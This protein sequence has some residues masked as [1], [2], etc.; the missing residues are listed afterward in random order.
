[1]ANIDAKP[2]ILNTKSLVKL[3]RQL[4][5]DL[6]AT[7]ISLQNE[8]QRLNKAVVALGKAVQGKAYLNRDLFQDLSRRLNERIQNLSGSLDAAILDGI[9]PGEQIR[10]AMADLYRCQ[11]RLASHCAQDGLAAA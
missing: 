5:A 1:M 4:E 8:R 10:Q 3:V 2:L 11:E 7:P 6:T 9:E